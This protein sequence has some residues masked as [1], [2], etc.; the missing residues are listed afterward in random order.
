M[1]TAMKHRVRLRGLQVPEIGLNQ[2]SPTILRRVDEDPIA[3][4]LTDLM[5]PGLQA[6]A[7][8]LIIQFPEPWRFYQ[9]VHR[10]FH[11]VL[12][13]AV[14]DPFDA[15]V[16]AFQPRLDPLKI[17]SAG[18]G[19]AASWRRFTG[20]K[21]DRGMAHADPKHASQQQLSQTTG[22]GFRCHRVRWMS[23]PQIPQCLWVN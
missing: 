3:G 4:I 9:P 6:I 21:P 15:D 8:S 23:I 11:L 7:D 2:N 1:V 17:E 10:V 5:Q 12:L 22:V 20:A 18:T 19:V 14:C 16:P 13:E